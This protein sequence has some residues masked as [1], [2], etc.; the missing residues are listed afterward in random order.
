LS[1]RV[2]SRRLLKDFKRGLS[3]VGLARK[4]GLRAV[5]VETRIRKVATYWWTAR[6]G[7]QEGHR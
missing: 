2:T 7:D 1:K 4:Y 5:D 6:A 3:M